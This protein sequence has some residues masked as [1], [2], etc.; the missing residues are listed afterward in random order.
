MAAS[1]ARTGRPT[2]LTKQLTAKICD[3]IGEGHTFE[4]CC[5]KVGISRTTFFVWRQKG[6]AQENGK[7]RDFMNKVQDAEAVALQV[8]EDAL[9]SHA[10]GGQKIT[11]TRTVTR[12]TG[13]VETTITTSIAQPNL[14][15]LL[16]ILERR[17]PERW[18][19]TEP[20][21]APIVQPDVTFSL[22]GHCRL[23][24]DGIPILDE[25]GN[26]TGYKQTHP[27]EN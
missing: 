26:V 3:L 19:R 7:Y 18:G 22:F 25:Q 17:S 23:G 8:I 1:K 15:I 11:E 5:R 4:H 20:R 12:Q 10:M 9:T 27:D 2:R 21:K 13:L 6:K 14:S 16:Q 24:G